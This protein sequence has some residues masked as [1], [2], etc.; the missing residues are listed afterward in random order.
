V[1]HD[2]DSTIVATPTR[3][4]ALESL[5]VTPESAPVITPPT[6]KLCRVCKKAMPVAGLKCTE[7]SSFQNWRRIFSFGTEFFALLIAFFS[8]LGVVIPEFTKWLNRHSHTQIRIVGATDQD[9]LVVVMNTGREPSTVYKFRA[10]F[11]NMPLSEADLNPVDLRE[12]LVPAGG[13]RLVH[14]Q[15][16]RLTPSAN[17]NAVAVKTAIPGGTLKLLAQIKE[18][19]DERPSAMSSRYTEYPTANL[20]PWIKTNVLG[21]E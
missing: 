4:T 6:E 2:K 12:F 9:L 20:S 10:S 7:C 21:M 3:V 16:P 8:V 11:V 19:T 15:T 18:S 1:P 14:L 5:G 13:S 17:S